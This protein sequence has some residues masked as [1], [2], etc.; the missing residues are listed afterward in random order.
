MSRVIEREEARGRGTHENEVAGGT[1]RARVM[2]RRIRD[3]QGIPQRT[4]AVSNV[5][6]KS[7]QSDNQPSRKTGEKSGTGTRIRRRSKLISQKII[8]RRFGVAVG[9]IGRRRIARS[10]DSALA[11]FDQPAGE[12]GSGIFLEPL[13]EKSGDFFAQI[14]GVCETREFVGLERVARRREQEFPGSLGTELRHKNLRR[15]VLREYERDINRLVIHGN[16]DAVA[17]G[18]WKCVEKQ[19]NPMG[20]CSGCAGD[21]EDP[22]WSAW[23]ADVNDEEGDTSGE[24]GPVSQEGRVRQGP[25]K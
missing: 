9:N 6:A 5:R 1:Q 8:G 11:L 2:P 19:E 3:T 25:A 20:C 10:G 21:Y 16:S 17:M 4:L 23:E 15:Q 22:D 13:V 24:D 14:G 12:I 7:E 18:L